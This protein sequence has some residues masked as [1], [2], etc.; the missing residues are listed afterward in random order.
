VAPKLPR[1]CKNARAV[2]LAI[3]PTRSCTGEASPRGNAPL[4]HIYS[5]YATVAKRIA[6]PEEANQGR[7]VLYGHKP[8]KNGRNALMLFAGYARKRL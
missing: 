8:R 6:R 5:A 2:A 7:G 1:H 4:R 3:L